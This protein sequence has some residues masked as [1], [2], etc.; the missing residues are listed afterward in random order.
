MDEPVESLTAVGG[1]GQ[2]GWTSTVGSITVSVSSNVPQVPKA[3]S[4]AAAAMVSSES[5]IF[6]RV[7]GMGGILLIPVTVGLVAAGAYVLARAA[8]TSVAAAVITLATA[9]AA[10]FTSIH[11][12]IFLGIAAALGVAGLV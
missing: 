4:P 9:A 8:D 11:P 6:R 5:R 10:T 7:L 3:M 1:G 12:L 2:R